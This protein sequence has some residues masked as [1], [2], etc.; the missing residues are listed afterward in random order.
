MFPSWTPLIAL[1]SLMTEGGSSAESPVYRKEG[2]E[3]VLSPGPVAGPITSIEWKHQDNFASE[4]NGGD[5]VC[6]RDF[7]G[8]CELNTTTGELIITGLFKNN[9]GSYTAEINYRVHRTTEILVISAVPTPTIT[10]RC[11]GEKTYCVL[12]CEGN[13][14]GAEPVSY[15]W[16]SG[17]SRLGSDRKLTITKE[18]KE[19]WFRCMLVN[20]VSSQTSEQVPNPFN[21]SP[22][23]KHYYATLCSFI[24]L[25]LLICGL[26]IPSCKCIKALAPPTETSAPN[27][28][29]SR[30]MEEKK[31]LVPQ[32]D[33]PPSD[34]II[35]VE[36]SQQQE[37]VQGDPP[38]ESTSG[39]A[40]RPQDSTDE[41]SK[42]P[43]QNRL[44]SA[45]PDE[46][47]QKL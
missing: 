35:K 14:A 24:L 13:T 19:E 34:V 15:E 10:T 20:P 9:S 22:D 36:A 6:Y 39:E 32:H 17:D 40:S 45:T 12:T 43:Q 44:K 8:R 33:P 38:E 23:T 25:I 1:L 29:E 18:D 3:V 26:F 21:R 47:D 30:E 16:T 5:T 11:S 31:R 2:D 7:N 37:G 46:E 4:W 27:G 41:T 28:D 42:P